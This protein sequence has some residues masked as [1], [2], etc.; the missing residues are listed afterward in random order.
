MIIPPISAPMTLRLLSA[1]ACVGTAIVEMEVKAT[2]KARAGT[3]NLRFILQLLIG[4]C[5][6]A[7]WYGCETRSSQIKL[8]HDGVIRV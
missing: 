3:P 7:Y 6:L 8:S 1:A 4:C 2:I 5:C